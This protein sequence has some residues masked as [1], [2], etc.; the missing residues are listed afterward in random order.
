MLPEFLSTTDVKQAITFR[1][2]MKVSEIRLF[3]NGDS[4]P[5]CPRCNITVEREYQSFCDRCGQALSWRHFA[6]AVIRSSH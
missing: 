4:F 3:E 5:V 1:T 2:P 6:K